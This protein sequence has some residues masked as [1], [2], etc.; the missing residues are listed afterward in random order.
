MIARQKSIVYFFIEKVTIIRDEYEIIK[1]K[2][3]KENGNIFYELM[4]L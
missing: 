1:R 2:T 4:N 3:T